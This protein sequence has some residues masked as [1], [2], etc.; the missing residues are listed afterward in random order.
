VP[1]AW[2]AAE[3]EKAIRAAAVVALAV[4][5]EGPEMASSK[6]APVCVPLESLLLE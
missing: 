5:A 3:G 2:E 4:T 1:L 6:E